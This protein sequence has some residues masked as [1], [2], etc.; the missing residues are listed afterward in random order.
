MVRPRGGVNGRRLGGALKTCELPVFSRAS[1][2]HPRPDHAWNTPPIGVTTDKKLMTNHPRE[3]YDQVDDE[4]IR[5][6]RGPVTAAATGIPPRRPGPRP[7]IAAI[8]ART[9][10]EPLGASEALEGRHD[11]IASDERRS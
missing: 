9:F 5:A 2:S 7:M 1:P 3:H 6:S 10:T 4:T 11:Y 8:S